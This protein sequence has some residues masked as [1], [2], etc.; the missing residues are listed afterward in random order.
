MEHS[1]GIG[2]KLLIDHGDRF[3]GSSQEPVPVAFCTYETF[4]IIF[5]LIVSYKKG[6]WMVSEVSV[7]LLPLVSKLNLP[8]VIK[9]AVLPGEQV[10]R[11]FIAT[12]VGE[13]FY[14]GDSEVVFFL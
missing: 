10:E 8:T 4:T 2:H 13:V 3:L 7:R 12:Q 14:V 5:F 6:V 11:L 1:I 9:T